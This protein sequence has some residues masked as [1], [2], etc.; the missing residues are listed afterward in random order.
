MSDNVHIVASGSKDLT[1][2]LSGMNFTE[3]YDAS[4]FKKNSTV[5]AGSEFKTYKAGSGKDIL[6]TS[7][8]SAQTTTFN[9]LSQATNITDEIHIK[10]VNLDVKYTGLSISNIEAEY[11]GS[12]VTVKFINNKKKAAGNLLLSDEVGG[13]FSYTAEV[14]TIASSAGDNLYDLSA[15][16][17]I[18]GAGIA[19]TKYD[20]MN[21][22]GLTAAEV[23]NYQTSLSDTVSTIRSANFNEF[24]DEDVLT[25][26]FVEG[27]ELD[28]V[29]LMTNTSELGALNDNAKL[30]DN[31]VFSIKNT[32]LVDN[33]ELRIKRLM[34]N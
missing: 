8:Q 25:N 9:Y 30:E 23:A 3:S 20:S 22:T 17:Y 26:D 31:T 33:K 18:E 21:Q 1:F 34:H 7:D 19:K 29:G 28:N 6:T 32:E 15:N 24:T 14:E 12:S 16:L 27:A 4:K 2:D 11:G 13:I 10:N 5:T